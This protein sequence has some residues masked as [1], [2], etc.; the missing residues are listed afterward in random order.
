MAIALRLN[1]KSIRDFSPAA[2][3]R[4]V[5]GHLDYTRLKCTCMH[6]DLRVGMGVCVCGGGLSLVGLAYNS[7]EIEGST[8]VQWPSKKLVPLS[9]RL[10]YLNRFVK[11]TVAVR[12]E[13]GGGCPLAARIRGGD[14]WYI[15]FVVVVVV[16]VCA[17]F[18]LLSL[19]VN[20]VS[21]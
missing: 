11:N 7:V 19:A 6:T 14:L 2:L 5:Q 4:S 15:Q 21:V 20:T 18:L 12:R 9:L 16:A 8:E 13:R 1:Y 17:L 3:A 10:P